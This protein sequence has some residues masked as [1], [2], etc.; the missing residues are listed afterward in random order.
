MFESKCVL[1]AGNKKLFGVVDEV[2]G[3][4]IRLLHAGR[5]G[6]VVSSV[7][8]RTRTEQI[9]VKNKM[10]AALYGQKKKALLSKALI[11]TQVGVRSLRHVPSSP[12]R[13]IS[14][15]II[16]VQYRYKGVGL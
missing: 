13:C 10:D 5:A 3:T 4:D 15:S 14:V 11:L 7:G 8:G 12:D 9:K 6:G 2:D 1:K 16:S